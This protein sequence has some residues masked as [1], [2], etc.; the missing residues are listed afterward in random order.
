MKKLPSIGERMA[1]LRRSGTGATDWLGP[2]RESPEA[3]LP[4]AASLRDRLAYLQR[5]RPP[6]YDSMMCIIA[7]DIES[8]KVR[9]QVA[10]YLIRQGCYRLQKSV[11][12]AQLPRGRYR[13][14]VETLRRINDRY[15]NEDSI[16]FL[17]LS[18]DQVDRLEMVGR[19]LYL[20]IARDHPHTLFW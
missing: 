20:Q 4:P 13:D 14:I 10:K 9:T 8:N 16:F 2:R 11:Y 6:T 3:A 7:Y 1:R 5:L 12:F 19:D 17:P 15:E 18:S